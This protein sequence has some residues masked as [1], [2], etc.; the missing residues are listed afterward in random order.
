MNGHPNSLKTQN[1][2]IN[3]IYRERKQ[4]DILI[5]KLGFDEYTQRFNTKQRY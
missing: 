5:R 2:I 1:K 4:Q 3:Q